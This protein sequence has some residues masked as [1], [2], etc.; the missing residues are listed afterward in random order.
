MYIYIPYG[1]LTI[2]VETPQRFPK[3]FWCKHGVCFPRGRRSGH[4]AHGAHRVHEARSC[5]CGGTMIF[6]M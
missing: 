5:D 1:K 4:G 3:G 2:D 6:M